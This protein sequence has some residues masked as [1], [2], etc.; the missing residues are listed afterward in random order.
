MRKILLNI[1]VSLDGYIEGPKGEIDWCFVDQDYGM[2]AFMKRIDTIFFGRRSYALALQMGPH[3]Y[4]EY[5][6]YVFSHT[7]TRG[8]AGTHIINGDLE[9]EVRKI[10]REKGKDIWLFGGGKLVSDFVNHNLIDELHLAIH[11]FLLGGGTPLFQNI[12]RRT[13]Y[14]L[15]GSNEY[16]TGLVQLVYERKKQ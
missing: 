6:K 15:K 3:L 4:P 10:Q 14:V 9:K 12:R 2:N 13:L 1:A 7:L 16:S 8:E 11:P 5:A